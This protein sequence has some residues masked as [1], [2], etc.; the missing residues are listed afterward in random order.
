MVKDVILIAIFDCVL[1][2]SES[3]AESHENT[4][5]QIKNQKSEINI[6]PNPISKLIKPWYPSTA[7]GLE[8]GMASI[9]EVDRGRGKGYSL[10][11][12]ATVSLGRVADS[13]RLRSTQRSR[14]VGTGGC[15]L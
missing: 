13:T 12:A 6:V 9:V 14:R 8:K 2:S 5:R 3:L 11:R 1:F 10:R 15:P 7:L 4:S